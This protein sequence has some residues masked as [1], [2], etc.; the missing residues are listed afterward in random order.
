MHDSR[1]PKQAYKMQL[2]LGENLN[3][4]WVTRAKNFLCD[5]GFTDILLTSGSSREWWQTYFSVSSKAEIT[6]EV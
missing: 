6:W 2:K 3:A 5:F 4:F 1:L